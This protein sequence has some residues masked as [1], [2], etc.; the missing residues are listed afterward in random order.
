M[1]P[2]LS[3]KGRPSLHGF[4]RIVV[5]NTWTDEDDED[6]LQ[7]LQNMRVSTDFVEA[8]SIRQMVPDQRVMIFADTAVVQC[9]LHPNAV[10]DTYP[11]CLSDFYHRSITVGKLTAV[12]ARMRGASQFFL[13]FSRFVSYF[14]FFTCRV[15]FNALR[16]FLL[17]GQTSRWAQIVRGTMYSHQRRAPGAGG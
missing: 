7:H 12:A 17:K 9:L 3:P 11:A 6:L 5:Q 4:D 1:E 13:E 14:F 15:F 16:V 2:T 10:V 8:D